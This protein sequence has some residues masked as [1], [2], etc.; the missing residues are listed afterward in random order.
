MKKET[1]LKGV[2]NKSAL[3]GMRALR[4]YYGGN[5]SDIFQTHWIPLPALTKAS[6]NF[7]HEIKLIV[8]RRTQKRRKKK[9]RKK[10]KIRKE[11]RTEKKRTKR[12]TK[13]NEKNKFLPDFVS[14]FFTLY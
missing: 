4:G 12:R 9:E 13:T 11:A 14:L 10:K 3:S 8:R 1:S 2:L 7:L 6:I 5:P